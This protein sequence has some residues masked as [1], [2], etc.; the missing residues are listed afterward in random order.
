MHRNKS[1]RTGFTRVRE[2]AHY[3]LGLAYIAGAEIDAAHFQNSAYHLC[4]ASRVDPLW[5][6]TWF[7]LSYLALLIGDYQHAEHFANKLLEVS[8]AATIFPFIGAEIVL[9]SIRLRQGKL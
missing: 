4:N 7:V 6:P 8:R 9:G 2:T 1:R 3:F 5:P